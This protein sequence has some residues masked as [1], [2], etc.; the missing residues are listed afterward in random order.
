M[1]YTPEHI[2]HLDPDS[3]YVFGSYADGLHDHGDALTALKYFGAVM[4]QESGLQGQSY[5]IPVMGGDIDKM[6]P[7]VDRFFDIAREWDQTMFY[8][9][10]IACDIPG[11]TDA[12]V[13]PLFAEALT[14]YN[15]LLPKQFVEVLN[16]ATTES[17][18]PNT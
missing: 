11:V 1:R 16:R 10:R 7:Y 2:T 8:V 18:T 3:I 17:L 5:A 9:T 6:R 12:D 15:V 13:A 4:G 14:L